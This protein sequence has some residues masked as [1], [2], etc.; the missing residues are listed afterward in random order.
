MKKETWFEQDDFIFRKQSVDVTPVVES[1][2]ALKLAGHH[3]FSENKHIGRVPGEMLE[4][5]LK[6]A[7]VKYTDKAAVQEV[8]R[9][10]LMSNEFSGLRVWEGSY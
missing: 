6:E 7:G 8:L 5:W 2:K 1:A 3:G 10:K 9:K 4:A